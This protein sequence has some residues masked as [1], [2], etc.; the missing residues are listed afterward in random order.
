MR[1]T[2]PAAGDR[3]LRVHPD[4]GQPGPTAARLLLGTELR[5]LR[6][7]AGV[8]REGAAAAI[9]GSAPKISRLELGRLGFK[10]RDVGDLLDLYGLADQRGRATLL[11]LARRA[12]EPGWWAAYRDVVPDWFEPYLGLEQA[13]SIIRTYEVQLV[14][15]L[16]QTEA[17]A[18]A[19]FQLADAAPP[20]Q[21]EQRVRLRMHRQQILRRADPPHLWAVIDEAALSRP[22][23]GP[24]VMR[25]QYEHLCEAAQLRHVN[26][27]ILPFR[28][29]GHSASGGPITILRFPGGELA[30]VLYLEQLDRAAYPARPE[31]LA[32]YWG[33]LNNLATKA[34]PPIA[35]TMTL[36]EY[37]SHS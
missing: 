17:Y 22:I 1:V 24:A 27:Q 35:S 37:L 2:T 8:T 32:R 5:K 30:D 16:L 20:E 14:P 33:V 9:R 3:Q 13:A 28:A 4:D 6:E 21:V 26:I 7:A 15:G 19:V 31:D 36:R 11:S 25:A 10:Q 34:D 12:N 18:R 23:G 29:G